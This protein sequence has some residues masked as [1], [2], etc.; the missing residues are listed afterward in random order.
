MLGGSSDGLNY[1]YFISDHIYLHSFQN[2][3]DH[4]LP[5]IGDVSVNSETLVLT[6]STTNSAGLIF[7]EGAHMGMVCVCVFIWMYVFLTIQGCVYVCVSVRGIYRAS[8]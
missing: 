1:I 6:L 8:R 2:F 3:I 5:G 7:F 4:I